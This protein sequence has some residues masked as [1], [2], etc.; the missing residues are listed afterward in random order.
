MKLQVLI[1]NTACMAKL[2]VLASVLNGDREE[3]FCVMGDI[4]HSNF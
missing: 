3:I 2:A 4:F 1:V